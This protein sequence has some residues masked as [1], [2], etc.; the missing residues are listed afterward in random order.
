MPQK[1]FTYYHP[2]SRGLDFSGLMNDIKVVHFF[3]ILTRSI[4]F[5]FVLP[6]LLL[7][8]CIKLFMDS[9][10]N[11]VSYTP[12]SYRFSSACY[13]GSNLYSLIESYCVHL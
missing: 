4:L 1:T 8:V 5:L 10:L 6:F 9:F 2:E 12:T 11:L 7:P 13:F 3:N